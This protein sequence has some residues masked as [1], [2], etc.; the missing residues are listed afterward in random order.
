MTLNLCLKLEIFMVMLLIAWI[1]LK[2]NS[3]LFVKISGESGQYLKLVER[4]K[5]CLEEIE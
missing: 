4:P 2:A 3:T 5:S 1:T